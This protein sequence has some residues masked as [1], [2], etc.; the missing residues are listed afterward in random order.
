MGCDGVDEALRMAMF[1]GKV[2][3]G[4]NAGLRCCWILVGRVHVENEVEAVEQGASI[5]G[6]N[7]FA[8]AL[9]GHSALLVS[10]VGRLCVGSGDGVVVGYP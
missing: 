3:R 8:K 4:T 5:A 9:A 6:G 1:D 10:I 2:A 7:R